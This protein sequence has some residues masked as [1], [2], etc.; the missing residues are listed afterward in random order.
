MTVQQWVLWG[1]M[2]APLSHVAVAAP[3]EECRAI[4]VRLGDPVPADACAVNIVPRTSAA[5]FSEA[6]DAVMPASEPQ[7]K[8]LDQASLP[9][10]FYD[11]ANIE[12]ESTSAKV[13]LVKVAWFYAK[14]RHSESTNL[15]YSSASQVVR[16][17]CAKGTFTVTETMLMAGTKADGALVDVVNVA[18]MKN[19]AVSVDPVQIK[20]R[21]VVCAKTAKK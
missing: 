14:P 21:S 17:N 2:L 7:W 16:M 20:V 10:I 1:L 11:Q 9:G 6:Q 12:A 8:P 19:A 5:S 3:V 15:P 18:G 4:T 13:Y